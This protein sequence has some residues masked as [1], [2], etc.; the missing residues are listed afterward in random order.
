MHG[1]QHIKIYVERSKIEIVAPKEEEAL[2]IGLPPFR[3]Q[4]L[5]LYLHVGK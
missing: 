2:I 3:A 1:Q 4:V 5:D